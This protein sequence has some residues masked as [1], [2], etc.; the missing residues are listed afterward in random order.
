MLS[1]KRGCYSKLTSLLNDEKFSLEATE[2]VRA[3]GYKKGEPNLT[4]DQFVKWVKET[5]NVTICVGTASA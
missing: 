4:L 3:N 2:Y 1:S 5:Y